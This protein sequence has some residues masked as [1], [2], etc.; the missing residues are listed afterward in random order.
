MTD[1]LRHKQRA[2]RGLNE[3]APLI[4]DAVA[5]LLA[6]LDP[7]TDTPPGVIE[8]T[9]KL[10]SDVIG[11]VATEAW[12]AGVLAAKDWLIEDGWQPPQ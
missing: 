1:D 6:T 5:E 10:F 7:E 8:A 2:L 11:V 9:K 12:S 4:D 3:T